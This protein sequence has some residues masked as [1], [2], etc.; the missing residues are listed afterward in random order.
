MEKIDKLIRLLSDA[1]QLAWEI[2]G[3]YDNYFD[4]QNAIVEE[5]SSLSI[6]CDEAKSRAE[7]IK[8]LI[9]SLDT[10]KKE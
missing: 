6:D 7:S 3:D 2:H 10:D 8:R 1:W 5:L 4:N 9:E